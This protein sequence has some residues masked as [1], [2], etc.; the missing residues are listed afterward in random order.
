MFT[1]DD[2]LPISALQHL[3]FCE[4]QWALMYLE[5]L[6][7]ENVLTVQGSRMHEQ[8]DTDGTTVRGDLRIAAGVRLR[9]LRLGLTGRADI[10]EFHR[11]SNSSDMSS[12]PNTAGVE[13]D[14]TDG[15]WTPMPVEY[16]HGRPKAIRCDEVQLCA[17]ALCLEEMLGAHVPR[18]M[19]FY[20]KTRRRHEVAVDDDLRSYTEKLTARLHQM[21]R[22][23]RTPPAIYGR[24][25]RSC[26][27]LSLC[28]P[29]A[30]GGRSAKDYISDAIAEMQ[31]DQ[32]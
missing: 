12:Q 13:L 11:I 18:G 7:D 27:M 25:C 30:T 19:L 4:R 32:S 29:R 20:G 2:L 9:S 17:Q 23:G 21:T 15:L 14:G 26:S 1:E 5:G 22:E 10:V 3:E 6:W 28:L 8:A 24:R 31:G 16:K